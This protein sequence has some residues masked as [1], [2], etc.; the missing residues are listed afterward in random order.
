MNNKTSD[1]SFLEQK[2]RIDK[3]WCMCTNLQ[4][5]ARDCLSTCSICNGKDAYGSSI[6]R[7]NNKHKTIRPN[8]DIL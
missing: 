4:N 8:K 2:L 5:V 1:K 6:D 3:H 7:P